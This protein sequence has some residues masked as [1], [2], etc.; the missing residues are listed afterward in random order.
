MH[1]AV[2]W[3]TMDWTVVEV[4]VQ[5]DN[6][7][8]NATVKTLLVLAKLETRRTEKGKSKRR[9]GRLFKGSQFGRTWS[10]VLGCALPAAR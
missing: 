10:P 1:F 4:A 2:G 6:I 8:C 5:R 7:E 3:W 9:K